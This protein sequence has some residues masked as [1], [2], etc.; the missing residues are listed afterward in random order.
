[1][2]ERDPRTMLEQLNNLGLTY[3]NLYAQ[4]TIVEIKRKLEEG[5]P[6]SLTEGSELERIYEHYCK[7]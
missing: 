5:K 6:L 2:A 7:P 4:T 1:M 3:L